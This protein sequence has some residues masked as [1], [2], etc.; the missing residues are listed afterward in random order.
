MRTLYGPNGF[1]V[2]VGDV[3]VGPN[4]GMTTVTGWTE[5]HKEGAA[6]YVST[7]G[8]RFYVTVFNLH[9]AADDRVVQPYSMESD[10][11]YDI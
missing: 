5:P 2:K 1:E 9:W 11:Y 10:P 4:I 7:T 3:I 6:G 8:G